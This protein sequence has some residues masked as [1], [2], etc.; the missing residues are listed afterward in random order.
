MT[1]K[2]DWID[3][4][5][6]RRRGRG[7]PGRRETGAAPA[8]LERFSGA[9]KKLAEGVWAM[10]TKGGANAGWIPP[11]ATRSSRST[12]AARP[13]GRRGDSRRDHPHDGPEERGLPDPHERL[14][15]ARGRC[16]GVR[17]RRSDDHYPRE[18]RGR[19]P[20]PHR[21]F[22]AERE[23]AADLRDPGPS[24]APRAPSATWSSA[25]SAPPIAPGTS[26]C[27]SRRTKSSSREI[28][29]ESYLLPPLFSKAIDPAGW[30]AALGTLAGLHPTAVVPGYGPIRP[31]EAIAVTREY[32]ART[33]EIAKK[34]VEDNTPD[35]AI[36]MR[37]HEPDMRIDGLPDDLKK[38]HEA[39]VK[40]LV[41]W[42]KTAKAAPAK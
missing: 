28:W 2:N 41:T 31:P 3:R 19:D 39:N 27:C 7:G 10:M 1:R 16:P 26:P 34:L 13:R 12:P 17:P 4:G 15:T 32:L 8:R 24:G 33:F 25:T 40:A 29:S 37:I 18:L 35:N 42:L 6:D 9:P 36:E 5:H 21:V 22:A 30:V 23:H 14:R 11:S 20:E 38:S